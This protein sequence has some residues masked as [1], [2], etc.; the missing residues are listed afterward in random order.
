[1]RISDW[2]SDVCSSDLAAEITAAAGNVTTQATTMLLATF[3]RT[4]DSRRDA[5]TPMIAPVIV[6]V[7]DTGT[8][9]P[10]APNSVIAPPVPAQH[11]CAGLSRVLFRPT[12]RKGRGWGKRGSVRV[13]TGWCR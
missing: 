6:C 5:P 12:V 4:A 7:V 13:D 10:V 1:M 9:S 3:H 11:T 2:S 8:P